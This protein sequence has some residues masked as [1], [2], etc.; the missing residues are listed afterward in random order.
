VNDAMLAFYNSTL[1]MAV[2]QQVTTFTETEFGR[3]LQASAGWGSDHAWGNHQLVL[4]GAVKGGALFGTFPSLV[5]N[6]PDDASGRGVWIPTTSLDQYGATLAAW[7]G[8]APS[9]L[10]SIFTNLSNFQTANLGFL[11]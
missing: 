10:T 9:A 5:L 11:G 3:T 7:F 4:G 8:V 2:D 1:E 6:G